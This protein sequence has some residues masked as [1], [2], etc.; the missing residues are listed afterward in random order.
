M[1]ED[2]K[3]ELPRDESGKFLSEE[4]VEKRKNRPP[5]E[6]LKDNAVH[7]KKTHD[8][9]TLLDVRV[10]NPLKKIIELLEDIKKQKAF[11]FTLKGSLGIMGI[12]LAL[13]L[14]G[15]F[16]GSKMLCDKGTQSQIGIIKILQAPDQEISTVPFI[17][18][19]IDMYSTYF[20][21]PYASPI[22]RTVLIREDGTVIYLPKTTG[23]NMKDFSEFN[24][25]AT[26][27]YDSCSQTLKINSSIGVELY[28]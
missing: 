6:N 4:E 19:L 9:D 2:A 5:V 15:L 12:V 23:V 28:P 8:P 11:S 25:I 10:S 1:P 27:Q 17:G 18:P 21:N 20:R 13:S 22:F 3:S 7:I 16:G 14:F 24:V 26:G